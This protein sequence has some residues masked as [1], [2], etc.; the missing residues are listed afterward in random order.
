ME[1]K[2]AGETAEDLKQV[3][4]WL[5]ERSEAQICVSLVIPGD[6]Q[7]AQLDKEVEILN[8]TITGHI[9]ELRKYDEYKNRVITINNNESSCPNEHNWC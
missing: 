4:S 9:T 6:G 5:L 8:R 7:Y 1:W 2:K 3:L